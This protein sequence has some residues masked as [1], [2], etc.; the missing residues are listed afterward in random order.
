MENCNVT[1]TKNR[2]KSFTK[3][4]LFIS[5]LFLNAPAIFAQEVSA[6]IEEWKEVVQT[7]LNAGVAV[8]AIVGGFLIFIQYMQ[9]ND[10]AQKNFIK[11]VIGLAIFALIDLIVGVFLTA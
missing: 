11:F 6:K 10:Q 5:A 7:S 8:F 4:A 1:V 2:K 9:G 3:L